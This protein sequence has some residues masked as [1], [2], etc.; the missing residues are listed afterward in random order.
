MEKAVRRV[1]NLFDRLTSFEHLYAAAKKAIKGSGG[2]RDTH[3]FF[4]YLEPE[5]LCI[6]RELLDRSYEPGAYRYF[7]I[8][9]PKERVISVAPFRDRVVH[10]A[11]VSVLEPIYERV[12]IHDS[13]AT[14]KGKGTHRAVARAQQYVRNNEYYLKADIRK[15]FPTIDHGILLAII[16]RKI[17]DRDVQWLTRRII[18]R[19]GD[20]GLPIGNLTSQFFANVYL[21]VFDHY[22]KDRLGVRHYLRYMDDFVVFSNSKT[23]LKNLRDLAADFLANTLRLSL[24]TESCYINRRLNGLSFLGTRIFP[25]LIRLKRENLT[26]TLARVRKREQQFV[27]GEIEEEEYRDSMMSLMAH[28]QTYDTR[29]LL[30]DVFYGHVSERAPTG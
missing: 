13:Y 27:G 4:F 8:H 3:R 17:K 21:D 30:K 5:L 16:E 6:R 14:R 18:A 19:S 26:R 12:F 11:L 25:N 28:L 29:N 7:T 22:M 20:P 15:Y 24:K 1:G 10:H 9:E 2:K 23:E